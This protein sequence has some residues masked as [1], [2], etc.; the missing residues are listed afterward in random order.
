M[1]R[2]TVW[3][4]CTKTIRYTVIAESEQE[5]RELIVE[6]RRGGWNLRGYPQESNYNDHEII[7]VYADMVEE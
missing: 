6:G 5:A 1:K 2:F 7:E 4:Q 3:E